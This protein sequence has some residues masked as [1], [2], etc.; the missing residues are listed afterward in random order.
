MNEEDRMNFLNEYQK[1]RWSAYI[2]APIMMLARLSLV[3]LCLFIGSFCFAQMSGFK[4]VDW[5][6]VAIK[7]Q[8]VMIF[9]NIIS[10]VCSIHNID[11]SIY[12]SLM[13]LA[14]E[15][16]DYWLKIPLSALNVFEIAYWMVMS[17][18]VC[19]KVGANFKKSFKFVLSSYGV[20]YLFYIALLMFLILYFT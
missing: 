14:G 9:Y 13:F 17:V 2:V 16:V 15:N 3:S 1:K 10:C 19:K 11:I 5:W 7:A 4:Y 8:S 12:T 20:G 18:L 6:S